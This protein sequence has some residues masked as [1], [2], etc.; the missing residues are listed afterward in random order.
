M[1]IRDSSSQVKWNSE[2]SFLNDAHKDLKAD[3]IIANPPFNVSDWSGDLLRTDGRWQYGVPP[4]GSGMVWACPRLK[5]SRGPAFR[6]KSA[7]VVPPRL[8]AFRFNPSR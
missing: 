8:R 5:C 7:L 1:C 4:E 2:G 3:Y 6:S